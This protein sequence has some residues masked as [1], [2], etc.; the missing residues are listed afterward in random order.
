[1]NK[2]ENEIALKLQAYKEND[3][4]NEVIIPLLRI[5]GYLK[6][7]FSGGTNEE[8]KDI[9]CWNLDAFLKKQQMKRVSRQL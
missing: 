8:G 4:T 7:D 6:V 5:L 1:M 3:L 2:T 9:I